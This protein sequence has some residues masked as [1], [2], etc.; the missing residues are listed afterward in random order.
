MRID[1]ITL[2]PAMFQGPFH[3]SMIARAVQ[4]GAVE[5]NLHDLREFSLDRRGTVDDAPFGG[6]AGMVLKPDVVFAA[7]ES[8]IREDSEVVLLT[9]QGEQFAQPAAEELAL[10]SHLI[11][12]CPHYEGLDERVRQGLADRE[13]SIGD[14]ILT[15]GSLAAMVVVDAVVRLLPGVLGSAESAFA[16]SFSDRHRLDYP[17]YT[18]PADFRGMK[19]PEVLLS[20][21]HRKI[22]NWRSRQALIRTAGRRPDL[23]GQGC[24][25]ETVGC[26]MSGVNSGDKQYAI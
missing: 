1:I 2:F 19:V 16:D 17:Q 15:N 9:P 10:G 20:G 5:I 6:G 8:V 26:R 24:R 25:E 21:D 3:N 13:L 11:M 14:Y 23:M 22:E 12:I 18:R 4:Q 7:V